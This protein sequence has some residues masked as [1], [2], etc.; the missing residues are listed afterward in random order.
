MTR[1]LQISARQGLEGRARACFGDDGGWFLHR[2][3]ESLRDRMV[4]ELHFFVLDGG[5][6][7]LVRGRDWRGGR[8]P[9]PAGVRSATRGMEP[10]GGTPESA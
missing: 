1:E 5:S 7:R 9:V 8:K 6:C 3:F 2:P 10:E 4:V